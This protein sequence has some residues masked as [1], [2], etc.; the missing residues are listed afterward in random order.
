MAL[1]RP[2]K[3]EVEWT[4]KESEKGIYGRGISASAGW[5]ILPSITHSPEHRQHRGEMPRCSCSP[6]PTRIP[7]TCLSLL[8]FTGHRRPPLHKRLP[9]ALDKLPAPSERTHP[10]DRRLWARLALIG[11][12]ACAFRL[13]TQRR[14]P[15]PPPASDWLRGAHAQ[16]YR[17]PHAWRQTAVNWLASSC[18]FLTD[19]LVWQVPQLGSRGRTGHQEVGKGR[20]CGPGGG[21]HPPRSSG[22]LQSRSSEG[23]AIGGYQAP[24]PPES[25][26]G[27]GSSPDLWTWAIS[28]PQWVSECDMGTN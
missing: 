4:A 7:R 5:D 19:S 6:C 18:G 1:H 15:V 9:G 17:G 3:E 22:R 28:S 11:C 27:H 12:K 8:T 23:Q 21:P 14:P 13:A 26:S 25:G 20:L 2:L 10:T 24:S 16:T